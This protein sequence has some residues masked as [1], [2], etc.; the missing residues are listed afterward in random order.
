MRTGKSSS[1]FASTSSSNNIHRDSYGGD[2]V[3]QEPTAD[4]M[5]TEGFIMARISTM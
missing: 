3:D 5:A 2:E 4:N 1:P